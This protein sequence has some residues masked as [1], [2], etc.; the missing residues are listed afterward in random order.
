MLPYYGGVSEMLQRTFKKHGVHVCH[1]PRLV[2]SKDEIA[3]EEKCGVIY[4]IQ[5]KNC[6]ANYIG[7]TAK[8]QGTRLNEHRKSVQAC[9]LKSVVSKHAKY[10][11]HSI[12]SANVKSIGRK[13]HFLLRKI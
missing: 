11:D 2:R 3:D 5:C 1:K 13:N 12:H 9:D 8:K 6:D 7:E 10:T 4:N